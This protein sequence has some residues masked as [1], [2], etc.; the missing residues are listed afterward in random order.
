MASEQQFEENL[1]YLS[2]A[3]RYN[4]ER[5]V[6]LRW[7]F[8][9]HFDTDKFHREAI[10]KREIEE[11]CAK[12]LGEDSTLSVAE[13]TFRIQ[14]LTLP[15]DP[16]RQEYQ[17]YLGLRYAN[18]D[19]SMRQELGFSAN[20]LLSI[21]A[22]LF[23]SIS[24]RE[25]ELG[26]DDEFKQ[27]ETKEEYADIST[28]SEPASS[29]RDKWS[30]CIQFSREDLISTFVMESIG[31]PDATEPDQ[32]RQVVNIAE[33]GID[34]LSTTIGPGDDYSN[35]FFLLHPIVELGDSSSELAVPFPETLTTTAQFRIENCLKEEKTVQH[36]ED[37]EKGLVVEDL[38][39]G[40]FRTVPSRNYIK[41][42]EYVDPH[43]GESDGLL[44]FED[45]YW[46]IEVKSHPIF[47][48]LPIDLNL[49]KTRFVEKVREA[50]EQGEKTRSFLESQKRE[51]GL[52]YNLS[53]DKEYFEKENGIIVVLDGLL[54]TLFAHNS[55]LDRIFGLKEMYEEVQTDRMFVVSLFDL[56]QLI[57][58]PESDQ[59]EEFLLWRT[60]Y[61]DNMPIH[62]FNEREYWA[63]Y[64]DNYLHDEDFQKALDKSA[65]D[66]I[67][68][69]YISTRFNDKPYLSES[70]KEGEG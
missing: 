59:F 32:V 5:R 3:V 17:F 31:P 29:F 45:S 69:S 30:A 33:S 21:E 39:H 43:P 56:F 16:D 70:L 36:A 7:F 40:A 60:G 42:L 8:D 9:E 23:N 55:R 41:N 67:I 53:G 18:L 54:P 62:G 38:S 58:Q 63:M 26:I 44:L 57:Q 37:S 27:Y 65:E 50:V 20:D 68:T 34:F 25:V 48:K 49:A 1:F 12:E 14:V 66:E 51:F 22:L 2:S 6:P 11:F 13:Q 52:M 47:R 35:L 4:T 15:D 46:V 24:A 61:P 28:F 19:E 64:F 10:S